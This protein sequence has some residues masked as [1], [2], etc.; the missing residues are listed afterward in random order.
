MLRIPK[1]MIGDCW[2]YTEDKLAH[3][4]FLTA[5]DIYPAS[6]RHIHW[7]IG[8]AVSDDLINWEYVG[9]ALKKG[10]AGMWDS[11]T[12]ATGGIVKIADSY[13]M[14]YTGHQQDE[15]PAV[16]RTGLAVSDDLYNWQKFDCN[17]I[18]EPDINYYEF[19]G[20]GKRKDVHWRDPFLFIDGEELYQFVCARKAPD[21]Q[22]P[23]GIVGVAKASV[24]ELNNWQVLQPLTVDPMAEELEC[25]SIHLIDGRYYLLFCT[26][27]MLLS[28]NFKAKHKE[29]K[30]VSTTYCMVS[31]KLLG[32]YKL[33]G[34]GEII[35]QEPRLLYAAQLVKWQGKLFILGTDA[36]D[37]ISDPKLIKATANGLFAKASL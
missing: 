1:T 24:S 20:T 27:S 12:L 23:G 29:H 2:F 31:D 10:D 19:V 7:D 11:K 25:P 37:Q 13:V 9:I 36:K 16:Q 35:K 8:H 14:G 3:C 18:T 15:S 17:P 5:P 22:H 26:H 6:E 34:T 32:P 33:F 21:S 4:F 28:D 30:F